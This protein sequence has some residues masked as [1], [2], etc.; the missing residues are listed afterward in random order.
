VIGTDVPGIRE[1][2]HH[3]KNGLLAPEDASA[4]RAAIQN[5]L[6]DKTLRQK[7]GTNAYKYILNNNSMEKAVAKEYAIYRKIIN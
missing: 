5:P 3:N 4:L 2:I 6:A 7:L 1:I